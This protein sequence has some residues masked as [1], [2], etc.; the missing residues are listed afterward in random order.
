MTVIVIYT[1]P[2]DG[3][4]EIARATQRGAGRQP[5]EWVIALDFVSGWHRLLTFF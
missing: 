1:I 3:K 5:G 4:R 2:E